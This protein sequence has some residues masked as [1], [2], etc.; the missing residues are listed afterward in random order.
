MTTILTT[1]E[2][3]YSLLLEENDDSVEDE[4]EDYHDD[5]EDLHFAIESRDID[6]VKVLLAKG[7]DVTEM[8]RDGHQNVLG[9]AIEA[10]DAEFVTLLLNNGAN[11]NSFNLMCAI[12][13][14]N[15]DI[16]AMLVLEKGVDVN[17]TDIIAED[18][19]M[20]T[21]LMSTIERGGKFE[22][23]EMLIANGADVNLT[24]SS[25]YSGQSPLD[26]AIYMGDKE[27][28]EFLKNKGAK[29]SDNIE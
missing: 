8:D 1:N 28:T 25:N 7:A 16:V 9:M 26:M 17:A 24:C 29:M 13:E 10:G 4:V 2:P 6:R 18:P 19:F 11:A 14:D 5:V 3:T 27:M 23:V 21:P 22:I 12:W 20:P 15:K